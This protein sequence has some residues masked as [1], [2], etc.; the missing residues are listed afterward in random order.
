M[1]MSIRRFT[2]LTNAFSNHEHMA[3]LYAVWYNFVK[4]HHT[5]KCSPAM[6]VGI[7]ATLWSM[8]DIAKLIDAQA[9]A[10]KQRGPYKTKAQLAA[11]NSN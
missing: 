5:L 9:E 1:R 10:P 3:R 6:A 7:S 8:D 11:E 2:R 4:M